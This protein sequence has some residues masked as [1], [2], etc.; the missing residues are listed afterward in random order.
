MHKFIRLV[1]IVVAGGIAVAEAADVER[2]TSEQVEN[3]AVVTLEGLRRGR[4]S[5]GSVTPERNPNIR[6]LSADRRFRLGGL[7]LR[8]F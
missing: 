1:P 3:C 5:Q 8:R 6:G 7:G 2:P 4:G